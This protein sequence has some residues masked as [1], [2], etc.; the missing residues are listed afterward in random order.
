MNKFPEFSDFIDF[1]SL[2]EHEYFKQP[3][4][5]VYDFGKLSADSIQAI[6]QGIYSDLSAFS[7]ESTLGRRPQFVST[8]WSRFSGCIPFSRSS[9]FKYP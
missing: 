6:I 7:M 4:I 8:S 2:S 5:R 3:S 1:V 9:F